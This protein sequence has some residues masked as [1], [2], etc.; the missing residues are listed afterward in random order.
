M[1]Q[2]FVYGSL[3]TG[4]SNHHVAAPYLLEFAPG[5]IRGRL[6]DLG[7]YPAL[8]RTDVHQGI[9]IQGEWFIVTEQGLRAMDELEEYYGPG[10]ANVYDRIWVKDLYEEREGW[11]YVWH[12]DR[13]Y[14][15][16]EG[17]SWRNHLKAKTEADPISG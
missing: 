9:D 14:P 5:T 15:G 3:L 13:G 4:E 1:I 10:K 12:E 16:I 8:V 11:V 6:I 2:I 17:G 7:P